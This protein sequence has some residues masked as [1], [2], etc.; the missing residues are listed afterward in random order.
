MP[1]PVFGEIC[2]LTYVIPAVVGII[3]FRKL[4]YPMRILSALC[5]VALLE[6]IL[7]RFVGHLRIKNYFVSEFYM[8][9]EVTFIYAVYYLY[10]TSLKQKLMIATPGILFFLIWLGTMLFSPGPQQIGGGMSVVSRLFMIAASLMMLQSLIADSSSR[11]IERSLFWMV[12]AVLL[13][14]TG[15][16]VVIGLS[17]RLLKDNYW[18]LYIAYHINWALL[19]AA[20]LL[21]S[22]AFLCKF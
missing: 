16:M 9:V 21:Y 2:L 14:A 12:I 3:R 4:A 7:A 10:A 8:V 18:L 6:I 15:S 13:Y 20:N 1:F 19:I 22:K 17:D 11:L 5:V